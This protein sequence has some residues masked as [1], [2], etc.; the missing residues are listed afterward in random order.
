M[1]KFEIIIPTIFGLEA[2]CAREV[3]ALGY[4]TTSVEAGRV[5][6]S[7]DFEAVARAN[8]WIRTG[9]RVLIKIAEF[10]AVSFE[11]LFEKTILAM[12]ASENVD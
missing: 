1:D 11:E 10:T 6:F 7:G 12:R 4:E 9:E 8:L 5:T 3:R 2:F